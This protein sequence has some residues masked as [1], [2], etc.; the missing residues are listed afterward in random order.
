[1]ISRNARS[2]SAKMYG[3][4]SSVGSETTSGVHERASSQTAAEATSHRWGLDSRHGRLQFVEG[5]RVGQ[6]RT[7]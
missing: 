7:T 4:A 5:T 6:P 3:R 2:R 1:M